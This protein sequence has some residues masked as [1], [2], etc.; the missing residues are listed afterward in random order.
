MVLLG[1]PFYHKVKKY[2]H[3]CI[4]KNEFPVSLLQVTRCGTPNTFN[5]H[6]L[7]TLLLAILQTS[8]K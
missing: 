6:L 5:K 2:N 8:Y 4:R 7:V 3:K 1:K